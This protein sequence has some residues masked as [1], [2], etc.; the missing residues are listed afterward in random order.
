MQGRNRFCDGLTRRDALRVGAGAIMG[1]TFSLP[2]LLAAD[3]TKSPGTKD[4]SLIYVFL[5]GGLSTIDTFDL[6]PDAP[7]EFRGEFNAINTNLPGVT[8]CEHLPQVAK[9]MDKFSQIRSF[10]HHNSD[11]GPADHYMLTG[12]FPQAGFNPSI[13]PNNQRPSHGSIIARK[14]G[15]RGA[16]PPYVCLPKVHPSFGS[17]YLGAVAAPFGI[18]ADP[19]APDFSVPNIVP[20]LNV[21]GSRLDDRQSLLAGL[22]EFQKSGEAKANRAAGTI[23]VF[24]QKA[25]ELM[26]S[27]DTKR[28]FDIHAESPKMRDTYGRNSLGQSCLMARRLVEAGVRCVTIDHSNWDTHDNNFSVLKKTLLPQFDPAISTLFRDLAERGMLDTTLVVITGEFGRTP[29]INKNA[30][31]DH[32]GPSFTVLLGGGGIHG[33]R[34]IGKSDARAEKPGSD[35]FGPEDLTATICQTL[36]ID[37]KEEFR[38]PDGRPVAIVNGG[39]VIQELF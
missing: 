5:H 11:H 13:T 2:R 25:F 31:R 6:K 17:A 22:D 9:E 39:K 1:S 29:R 37:P 28:A 3:K 18:D 30:G 27:A 33:G 26:T 21:S 14:L 35:P 7:A 4:V 15:P 34:V 8:V 16:V 32:W 38:T 23:G 20:P 24:Q 19:N 12:Y 36:G 10:R